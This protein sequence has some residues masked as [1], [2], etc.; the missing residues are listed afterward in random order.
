MPEGFNAGCNNPMYGRTGNIHHAWR[1]GMPSCLDCGKQLSSR[2][3]RRCVPCY[4]DYVRERNK[5]IGPNWRAKLNHQIRT[6]EKYCAWRHAIL[7]RDNFTCQICGIK[8]RK[9]LGK[10]IRI[11]VDH[12]PV[13]FLTIVQDYNV[14][15]LH[16]AIECNLLWDTDN[17]R[18]L[19]VD[20]HNKTKPGRSKT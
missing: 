17:G 4:Q 11:E 5:A 1:G 6:H 12:Y 15:S 7:G 3:C 14:E 9:G 8:N 2:R 20:C 19:C 10:S 16:D 13:S 18:V